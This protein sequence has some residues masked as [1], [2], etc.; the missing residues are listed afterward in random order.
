M[1][2]RFVLNKTIQNQEINWFDFIH[3]AVNNFKTTLT[4]TTLYEVKHININIIPYF[5]L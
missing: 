2:I 3:S 1:S 4:H 5:N